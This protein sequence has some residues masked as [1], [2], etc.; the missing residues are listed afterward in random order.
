MKKYISL[1]ICSVLLV[2]AMVMGSPAKAD[3]VSGRGNGND[4]RVTTV[5]QFVDVLDFF[6][7]Y[8]IKSVGDE[9]SQTEGSGFASSLDDLIGGN[10]DAIYT[11]ATFY[12]K[13]RA[14]SDQ[15]Y[16]YEGMSSESHATQT[17]EL[18]IYLTKTSAFYHSV[19]AV[20]QNGTSTS[21]GGETERY[22]MVMDFDMEIYM[23]AKVCYIKFNKFDMTASGDDVENENFVTS[24]MLGKW[25]DAGELG[26]Y[27]LQINAQNYEIL[28]D[29]GDYFDEFKLSNFNQ[30]NNVYTLREDY[31]Q[32]VFSMIFGMSFPDDVRGSF[33]LNLSNKVRP[34]M[35]LIQAYSLNEYESGYSINASSYAENNMVFKNINN[36]VVQFKA[37]RIYD[38]KD[39]VDE[40]DLW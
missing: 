21:S 27:F 34:T 9:S 8:E 7:N 18:T 17:R 35:S 40:E 5:E 10:N 24:N 2:I 30:S 25:F 26:V 13:S 6:N 36:T 20:M 32:E 33:S 37:N 14:T 31:I 16:S 19:G 15:R 4:T 29:I 3:V 38:L 11:S 22:S 23:T 1:I 28:G 12:N 39:Y